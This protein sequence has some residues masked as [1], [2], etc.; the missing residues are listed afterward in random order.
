M[1]KKKA[2]KIFSYKKNVN[3]VECLC[4]FINKTQIV[5]KIVNKI[6]SLKAII[7]GLSLS[8]LGCIV[9]SYKVYSDFENTKSLLRHEKSQIII[10]LVR[11]KD[12]LEVAIASNTSFKSE[13]IVERQKV[14]NL[15]EEISKSN[16]DIET[17]LK[18]KAEVDRLKGVVVKL[19]N[20]KIAL[21]RSNETLRMQR[22]SAIIVLTTSRKYNDTLLYLNEDLSKVIK[23]ASKISVVNLKAA[24][25]KQD[26]KGRTQITAKANRVNVL[27]ISF[28]VIGSKIAKACD[29]E[30]YIQIID[31]KNN[32]IGEKRSKNFGIKVLDYSFSSPIRF[33]NETLEVTADLEIEN[34]EKGTYYVNVFD[35]A[36]LASKTTF[37]LN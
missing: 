31:S 14:S 12:S 33:Q 19:S 32:I 18:Y 1:D 21:A 2:Y 35:K 30:Y 26:S 10:E 34:A 9:Y 8:L 6:P 20:D 36:E 16:L 28:L 15:L 27:Q 11:S 22:D 4:F 29:K 5:M 24:T 13:L 23:K 7:V 17:L 3:F 37:E 25:L